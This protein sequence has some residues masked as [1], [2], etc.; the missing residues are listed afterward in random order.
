M[1]SARNF[2]YDDYLRDFR[3][4]CAQRGIDP[5]QGASGYQVVHLTAEQRRAARPLDRWWQRHELWTD[6]PPYRSETEEEALWQMFS[7]AYLLTVRR[8]VQAK[9]LHRA[10]LSLRELHEVQARGKS[11]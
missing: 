1:T 2:H 8:V 10:M 5:I 9:R 6:C 7:E 4:A 11:S 3:A